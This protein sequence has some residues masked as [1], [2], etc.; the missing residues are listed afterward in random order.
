M[1]DKLLDE[2]ELREKLDLLFAKHDAIPRT[3]WHE[4]KDGSF[5]ADS[6]HVAYKKWM[7]N[8]TDEAL[9]IIQQQKEAYADSRETEL[10][11]ALYWMYYQYCNTKSGHM[12]MGAGE[13][14][15]ELLENAGYIVTDS[16]GAIIKDN[17]DSVE[18]RKL[19]NQL[20]GG[21]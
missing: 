14:A 18:Q 16:I 8:F 17:G 11:D 3:S 4:N 1:S 5:S 9:E 10:L 7:I 6:P 20:S 12:F 21:E 15:S 13:T 2:S 19:N